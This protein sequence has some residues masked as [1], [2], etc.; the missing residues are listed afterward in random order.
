MNVLSVATDSIDRATTN[1]NAVAARIATIS[2]PESG[3]SDYVDLSQQMVALIDARARVETSFAVLRTADE[4]S[5]QL[6]DLI[7]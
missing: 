6:V 5:K 4:I 3:A 2:D 7:G 1:L